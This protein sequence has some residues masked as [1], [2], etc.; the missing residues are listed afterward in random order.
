MLVG[1]QLLSPEQLAVIQREAPQRIAAAKQY[2][3]GTL[4]R[5]DRSSVP[6][7]LHF[8]EIVLQELRPL[9]GIPQTDAILADGPEPAAVGLQVDFVGRLIDTAETSSPLHVPNANR[10]VASGRG[11]QP[12]VPRQADCPDVVAVGPTLDGFL[13]ASAMEGELVGSLL[14]GGLHRLGLTGRQFRNQFV[15]Y[16]VACHLRELLEKL[17]PVIEEFQQAA[18]QLHVLRFRAGGSLLKAAES[19]GNLKRPV[20]QKLAYERRWSEQFP[21]RDGRRLPG[22]WT[23]SHWWPA[24]SSRPTCPTGGPTCPTGTVRFTRWLIT[25]WIDL[26]RRRFRRRGALLTRFGQSANEGQA[27][28]VPL[29]GGLQQRLQHGLCHSFLDRRAQLAGISWLGSG[30]PDGNRLWRGAVERSMTA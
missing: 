15:V 2:A 3:D 8:A 28:C 24:F 23:G 11:G 26:G 10:T 25:N 7:R 18:D 5:E 1:S 14:H 4:Q 16:L 13:A 21:I 20:G 6:G 29:V 12:L 19:G 22:G 17:G 30:L 27:V 9:A